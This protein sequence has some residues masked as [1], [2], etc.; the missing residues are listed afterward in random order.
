MGWSGGLVRKIT[1]GANRFRGG[2]VPQSHQIRQPFD[3][4]VKTKWMIGHPPSSQKYFPRAFL[5]FPPECFRFF[6]CIS[7]QLMDGVMEG[8]RADWDLRTIS[9]LIFSH[10]L[11]CTVYGPVSS[12]DV[13][14]TCH[15][16]SLET[17]RR[18]LS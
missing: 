5:S 8:P 16:M 6:F 2:T 11:Y 1:L 4:G 9:S 7:Q 3:Y 13:Q 17:D 15:M 14:Y 12:V 10:S 18:N